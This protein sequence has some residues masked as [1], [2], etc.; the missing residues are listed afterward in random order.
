MRTTLDIDDD[1]LHAAK[2][3]AKRERKTAGEVVSDLLR[4]ALTAPAPSKVREPKAIYGFKPFA[5]RGSVITN[6]LID[7]L[8]QDDAY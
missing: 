6:E 5:R 3:R 4:Q 8:R 7:Q 2:E 1:V